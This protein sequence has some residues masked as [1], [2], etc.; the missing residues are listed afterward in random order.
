MNNIF[1][2]SV[3]SGCF[4]FKLTNYFVSMDNNLKL[5]KKNEEMNLLSQYLSNLTTFMIAPY[6]SD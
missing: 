2:L 6:N 4:H 5:E 1:D 3:V